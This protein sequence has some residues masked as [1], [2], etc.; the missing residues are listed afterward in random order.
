MTQ[1]NDQNNTVTITLDDSID[2]GM[3]TSDTIVLNING[4]TQETF[5]WDH[6]PSVTYETIG[7]GVQPTYS[8]SGSSNGISSI[9]IGNYTLSGDFGSIY[10]NHIDIDKVNS[11][12]KEYPA[13]RKVCDN[14][15]TIYDMC[16]QDYEGKKQAGEL[17]DDVPF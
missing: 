17:D 10:D 9:D 13:L 4:S 12:C 15:K 5:T 7:T 16:K 6:T 11:M 8:I 14:F 1:S 3:S 2:C